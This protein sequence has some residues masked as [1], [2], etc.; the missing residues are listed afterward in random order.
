MSL[1]W[2][3]GVSTLKSTMRYPDRVAASTLIAPISPRWTRPAKMGVSRSAI[4]ISRVRSAFALPVALAIS[5]KT[6]FSRYGL[7]PQ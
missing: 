2:K 3:T 4:W 1:C 6:I 5:W 7:P